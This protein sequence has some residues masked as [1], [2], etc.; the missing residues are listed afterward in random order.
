MS[1]G[2]GGIGFGSHLKIDIS[3][4]PDLALI[5]MSLLYSRVP[6]MWA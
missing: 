3:V 2:Q 1:I 6:W 5:G 4:R